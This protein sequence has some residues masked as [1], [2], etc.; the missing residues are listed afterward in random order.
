MTDPQYQKLEPTEIHE[1]SDHYADRI[2]S[3]FAVRSNATKF[4]LLFWCLGWLGLLIFQICI[5]I[6][7]IKDVHNNRQCNHY[8]GF[9]VYMGIVLVLSFIHT[10]Y[11]YSFIHRHWTKRI[12]QKS[13]EKCMNTFVRL[14]SLTLTIMFVVAEIVLIGVALVNDRSKACKH[15]DD[16]AYGY[17]WILLINGGVSLLITLTSCGSSPFKRYKWMNN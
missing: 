8:E 5:T 16:W 11:F 2:G 1:I 3:W 9:Y 4:F 6:L 10:I 14:S 17:M 15:H 7:L 13:G 12:F